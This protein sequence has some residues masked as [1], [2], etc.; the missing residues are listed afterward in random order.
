MFVSTIKQ[1]ICE[2]L[3]DDEEKPGSFSCFNVLES[4]PNP[5]LHVNGLG[6]IGLPLSEHDAKAISNLPTTV[7]SPFGKGSETLV[8]TSIR[9]SW[10]ID[11]HQFKLLNP[12][13]QSLVRDIVHNVAKDLGVACGPEHVTAQLYK[14]LLY[15]KGA[16]FLPHQDSEKADG[17]FGTLAVILPS[18]H[19]GGDIHLS[20]DGEERV[21]R[22]SERSEYD[23]SYAAWY[24]DVTHEVKP[25]TSGYRLV[26]IYNLIQT[27]P[28]VRLLAPT[29]ICTI[30]KLKAI[31]PY[32]NDACEEGLEGIPRFLIYKLSHKYTEAALSFASLKGSDHTKVQLL[33]EASKGQDFTLYLAHAKKEVLGECDEAECYGY[34]YYGGYSDDSESE[35]LDHAK[36]TG[37]RTS[38]SDDV[39]D[40]HKIIQAIDDS[41][42]LTCVVDQNGKEVANEV[43]FEVEDIVQGNIFK[44]AP[45]DED[46]SG[47]TGNE[48]V[49]T[50]H[51]YHDSVVVL[52]PRRGMVDFR[53]RT[54]RNDASHLLKWIESLQAEVKHASQQFPRED[55]SRLCTLVIKHNQ[56]ARTQERSYHQVF[57]YRVRFA[58]H[59]LSK[60]AVAALQLDD[61]LLFEEAIVQI[62]GKPSSDLFEAVQAAIPRL[63]FD[64]LKRGTKMALHVIKH[65]SEKWSALQCLGGPS[66]AQSVEST[67]PSESV[68]ED[69][70]KAQVDLSLDVAGSPDAGDGTTVA[71][72]A[73]KYGFPILTQHV[74]PLIN[75]SISE[76]PFI[77][78]FL[79]RLFQLR[80]SVRLSNASIESVY[81]Q[82]LMA[83]LKSFDLKTPTKP[84]WPQSLLD[85]TK[86]QTPTMR[87]E[88]GSA[89][90]ISGGQLV[91]I[92][93]QCVTLSLTT[94]AGMLFEKVHEMAT[95]SST[96]AFQ[97][98]I[99]SYL[100][101]LV[102]YLREIKSTSILGH[103]CGQH[104]FQILQL[105]IVRY[106]QREPRTDPTWA[107]PT[108]FITCS[109]KDC[110]DL[111]AFIQDPKRK[112]GRFRMAKARRRHLH[113]YFYCKEGYTTNTIREG[114]PHTLVITKTDA[115]YRREHA[116]WESR[117]AVAKGNL[118][119]I[120][121]NGWLKKLLQGR[122]DEIMDLKVTDTSVN[123][124]ASKQLGELPNPPARTQ[125]DSK[126]RKSDPKLADAGQAKENKK[127]RQAEVV[128]LTSE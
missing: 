39:G 89:P 17:M 68:L 116:E 124:S 115:L 16:F 98:I 10:Q 19:S 59:V 34:G 40:C 45:D 104:V 33:K 64:C 6:T 28:A 105:Y 7:Q 118:N 74:V 111:K 35:D 18:K 25:V 112:E 30:S 12:R 26:L 5:A 99:V 71:E 92:L 58:D 48:G 2:A 87:T 100:S 126:K 21:F 127:P 54:A 52:I 61:V 9:K 4:C 128:D 121:G 95:I 56:I 80:G 47:Y 96:T 57:P 63:G 53:F 109:C 50:T 37:Y 29:S 38:E 125:K 102:V 67:D 23:Y 82:T 93:Q 120:A 114:S 122:Y 66:F 106:V 11:P 113:D 65:I 32:W 97:N 24:A 15:E 123:E 77:L 46:Y 44:R 75:N 88:I 94:H 43:D 73:E 60:T 51:F 42:K 91:Q 69:W 13:F 31:L 8:D 27:N 90:T 85:V 3:S 20:H 101:D 107:R 1:Q 49:S 81:S 41:Q 108:A 22:S 79:V 119:S 78:A 84:I 55:L 83:A 76:T 117:R 36:S 72:I 70:I 86:F 62:K 103:D 14:L 110:I